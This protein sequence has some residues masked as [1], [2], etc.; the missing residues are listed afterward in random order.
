VLRA[1]FLLTVIIF[2]AGNAS[3]EIYKWVDKQG[4]VHFGDKKPDS[5]QVEELELKIN[6]FKG[7]KVSDLDISVGKKVVMYTTPWCKYCK[8]AKTYFKKKN[9]AFTE[10]DI[11]NNKRAK[12]KFKKLGGKGVPLILVGKKRMS[13]FSEKGFERIYKNN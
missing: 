7:V 4:N 13:G 2:V 12:R 11:S 3:A 10:I 6:T 1:F 9:I 5:L 8:K